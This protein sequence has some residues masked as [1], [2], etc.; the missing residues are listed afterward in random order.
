MDLD[1]VGN[2]RLSTVANNHSYAETMSTMDALDPTE[3]VMCESRM[4][5]PLAQRLVDEYGTWFVVLL[6]QRMSSYKAGPWQGHARTSWHLS[7][8][9]SIKRRA[10]TVWMVLR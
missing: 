5:S 7:A 3:I 2:L 9:R 6:P 1:M 8:R 10:S 4:Q